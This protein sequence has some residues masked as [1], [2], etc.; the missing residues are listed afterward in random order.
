MGGAF[1]Y[2]KARGHVRARVVDMGSAAATL[3]F[4][5]L[6]NHSQET[7]LGNYAGGGGS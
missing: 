1:W 7:S 4:Y 5:N 2:N 6:V 3:D